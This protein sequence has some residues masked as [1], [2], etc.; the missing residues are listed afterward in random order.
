MSKMSKMRGASWDSMFL[1]VVRLITTLTSIL[2]TKI[3]SVGLSL[4]DY[5]TYSQ[6]NVIISLCTSFLFLGL[7]DSINYFYNS[8]SNKDSKE[9]KIQIINTIYMIEMIAGIVLMLGMIVGRTY[10]ASFFSNDAL[11]GLVLLIAIKPML[12]NML[13]FYQILFVSIGKAKFIA[14]RNLVVSVCK[15]LGAT[16]AVHYFKDIRFLFVFL[17]VLDAIQL[18]LFAMFFSKE[19]FVVNPFR[20]KLKN[21]RG[22]MRYGIPMGIFAITTSLTR[23]IDKLVIGYLSDTET[24]AIYANCSKVL[25]LDLIVS[26]FATVLIPYIMKYI[27]GN[28]NHDALLLFKNY[29]KIGYY[30]VWTFGVAIIMVS[31]QAIC[32]LY[33]SEYLVG[34][35]VFIIYILDSM[36]KFASMHLLITASGNSRLLMYYSFI[37]LVANFFLNIILYQMLGIVGPALATLIVTTAYSVAIL[38]RSIKIIDGKWSEIFD[39]KDMLS[40]A[41]LLIVCAFVFRYINFVMINAHVNQYIAMIV[42]MGVYGITVLLLCLKKIRAVLKSINSLKLN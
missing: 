19:G 18:C 17:I 15:V 9:N 6:A 31:N 14:I 36:I 25:P 30:S 2:L 23:D 21:V 26:S 29:L 27:S 35:S 33:S 38:K 16:I 20:G 5:G 39:Y 22:I 32:F 3:L 8:D 42:T 10:I 24:V 28:K 11:V 34:E 12:D 37:S 40:F 1:T 4:G 7:G 13:Y 41:V